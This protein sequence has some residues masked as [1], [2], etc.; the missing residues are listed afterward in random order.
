MRKALPF[1][2]FFL[3][4]IERVLIDLGPNT[5]LVTIAMLLSAAYLGRKQS[6]WLTF[7][8][9]AATD[10]IIGNTNIFIFTWSGFLIPALVS[11]GVFKNFKA[12]GLKKAGL[13]TLAGVG[14]NLFFYFWTNFG[15]WL[16]GTMYPN[17]LGGLVTSYV[18]ALPFLKMQLVSTLTFVPLG[19]IL[20]EAGYLSAFAENLDPKAVDDSEEFSASAG[21]RS[22]RSERRR[23]PE[24]KLEGA[25]CIC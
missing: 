25:S 23:Y 21:F 5:E 11:A 8:I 7:L 10:L 24:R 9:L 16:M 3:A 22:R 17:T 20:L 14:A 4:F 13:G 12:R 2:L 15:V 1:V 19:F 6:F 18:N